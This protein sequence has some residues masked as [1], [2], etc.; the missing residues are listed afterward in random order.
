MNKLACQCLRLDGV[1]KVHPY[2][3]FKHGSSSW[4]LCFMAAGRMRAA[5]S[6]KRWTIRI[7]PNC[8]LLVVLAKNK[9]ANVNWLQ[10]LWLCKN[11]I[12]R[13]TAPQPP[14]SARS[15]LVNRADETSGWSIEI[16]SCLLSSHCAS[17]S[18]SHFTLPFSPEQPL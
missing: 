9:T 13:A 11:P 2:K 1:L 7:Y 8:P 18:C 14:R 12:V 6:L 4:Q 3:V 5:I 17:P 15:L 10:P 16:S